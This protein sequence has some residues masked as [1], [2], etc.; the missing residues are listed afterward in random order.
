MTKPIHKAMC[1]LEVRLDGMERDAKTFL[2]ILCR[3]R[4]FYID[5]SMAVDGRIQTI[6]HV[7]ADLSELRRTVW[8]ALEQAREPG[9]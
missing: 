3:D 8:A 4:E 6:E 2:H 9:P 5:E 1:D 7:L